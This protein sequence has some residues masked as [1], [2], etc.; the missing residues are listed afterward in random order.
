M[1]GSD[2][3]RWA[4]RGCRIYGDDPWFFLRELAQNARDAGATEVRVHAVREG[5]HEV[6]RFRDDG[7]GMDLDH[8]RDFLFRLYASSKEDERTSAGQFGI[9]FWS[10]LGFEPALIRIASNPGNGA[11]SVAI[12]ADFQVVGEPP[13]E[14]L[15]KGTFVELRR[16]A[17]LAGEEAF[18]AAVRD[19]LRRYARYLR[20]ND[21]K[22][23]PL[24]VYFRDERIQEELAVA[25]PVALRFKDRAV[26]GAVGLA[27]RPSVELLARGLPV[28]K[29]LLLDELSY[30]GAD[31]AWRGEIAQ[32]LSPVFLLNGN[33]LNVVM[34]R[35]AVVDDAALARVRHAAARALQ[36]LVRAQLQRVLP[37]AWPRRLLEALRTL[38]LR[39]GRIP[40][41]ALAPVAAAA[42]LAIV[43]WQW[44]PD[45]RT[46]LGFPPGPPV[47]VETD[48]AAPVESTPLPSVA[49]DAGPPS[50]P[51]RLPTVYRGSLVERLPSGSGVWLRYDPPGDA[52]FKFL[53]ATRFEAAR[54]FVASAENGHSPAPAGTPCETAGRMG[55]ELHLEQG[56]EVVIP[57]PTGFRLDAA[58][59]QVNGA[60]APLSGTTLHGE[61]LV[62]LSGP[63]RVTYLAC[64]EA[65]PAPPTAEE[66]RVPQGFAQALPADVRAAVDAVRAAPVPDRIATAI[67]LVRT[68]VR[69]DGSEDAALLYE[70]LHG[71]GDWLTF[72]LEAGRGDCDVMNA[73][74]VLLLREMGLPARMAIGSVGRNGRALPGLHAWVEV[75]DGN[76]IVADASEAGRRPEAGGWREGEAGGRREAGG[77]R[78]GE[79]GRRPE[80]GGWREGEAG[81]SPEAG[82]WREGEA[83]RRPEA[84]GMA[85]TVGAHQ[86]ATG[87]ETRHAGGP[88][89]GP[90]SSRVG[91]APAPATRLS[92]P[93][94]SLPPPA[95]P[96]PAVAALAFAACL[97]ALAWRRRART[98]GHDQVEARL[99]RDEAERMLGDMAIAAASQPGAW[100]QADA[101][102]RHP[103][104]PLLRGRRR[105]SLRQAERAAQRGR[106]FAGGRNGP[107]SL[108][109]A[110]AEAGAPVLNTADPAFGRLAGQLGGIV[111]LDQVEA[112]APLFEPGGSGGLV[113][114]ANA[115]L[116]SMPGEKA[117]LV[118][119]PGLTERAMQD[120]DLRRLRV[121]GPWRAFRRFV[122]LRPDEAVERLAD[123]FARGDGG[124]LFELVDRV[125]RT[126]RFYRRMG[127]RLRHRCARSM[128][129]RRSE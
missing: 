78:E 34:S 94:S 75:L 46:Y 66:S 50:V 64:P 72:V 18:Q 108:A 31:E 80:A 14:G 28:W 104:L 92:P 76:W 113:E 68:L 127:A 126:I 83:G 26:E 30:R 69:Y 115:V 10:V 91:H 52:N 88:P 120:V 79:A 41:V 11:W 38:V 114:A 87:G 35:N 93:A 49:P 57:L 100:S 95:W 122:A 17:R 27:P 60:A 9:G 19:G 74:A 129:V 70:G 6:V 124:A 84:G 77:W 23:S 47:P 59:L 1:K 101:I 58:S 98:A 102:W 12:D 109:Y 8:A 67:A 25:G 20:R 63:S 21:R 123:R 97:A 4:V 48:A 86:G 36:R 62:R 90:G 16:P 107:G 22:A 73:L 53:T 3:K 116:R 33:D 128:V 125:S 44:G 55:I 106:L 61:P 37:V 82:G 103:I 111:D 32:G 105:L 65:V 39:I 13:V 119:C 51:P 121:T 2:F 71:A 96:W 56:T 110:A 29:G 7:R 40:V 15:G 85:S 5:D 45:I 112:L 117:A 42:L 99:E 89:D 118:I 24:P 54:G 43:L 81:R